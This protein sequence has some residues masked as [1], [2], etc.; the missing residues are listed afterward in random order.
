MAESTDGAAACGSG[1]A[2]V[3]THTSATI[4]CPL[5]YVARI[6]SH[7]R[8]STDLKGPNH[9][10]HSGMTFES[11][12]SNM[13]PDCL[14]GQVNLSAEVQP[15][16]PIIQCKRCHRWQAKNKHVCQLRGRGASH[17]LTGTV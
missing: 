16:Q 9:T 13:C 2:F 4:L 14:R 15:S 12:A 17:R 1:R 6:I 10:N 7:V 5:W 11:N 8:A 3:P